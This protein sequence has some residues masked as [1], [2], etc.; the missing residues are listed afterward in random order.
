MLTF[1]GEHFYLKMN[2]KIYG[3]LIAGVVA[4][5]FLVVALLSC[6]FVSTS[7]RKIEL[8][9]VE[10]EQALE[11]SRLSNENF[12]GTEL[13][14]YASKIVRIRNIECED[15]DFTFEDAFSILNA[16]SYYSDKHNLSLKDGIIIVHVESDFKVDAYNKWG[17]AYGLCQVTKPCLEEYNWKHG[18]DYTLE[19]MYDVNLNLEVGFWYYNRILT[20]YDDRYN[21]ITTTSDDKKIRDAYIA[22]NIGVTVFDKVG[23][24]GRNM[25]RNGKFPMNAYGYRKG[26]TYRPV[27]RLYEVLDNWD[28]YS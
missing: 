22:Y 21:Y 14:E 13:A 23:R 5:W 20:N 4:I 7:E 25:L 24:D 19:D 16:I 15:Y 3:Y 8:E 17:K 11:R 9:P 2:K 18:T 6:A 27:L 1:Y 26:E 10:I 28:Y 12:I